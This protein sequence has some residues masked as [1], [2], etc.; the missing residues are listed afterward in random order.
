[1]KEKILAREKACFDFLNAMPKDRR[2][3]MIGGYAV[4]AFEF[5]RLSVDLDITI[6]QSELKFFEKL[7]KEN[8]F[9]LSTEK[10][11]IDKVYSGKF[12]KFVKKVELPVSVDLLI[13]SVKSRQTGVSYSFD[14]LYENSEAREVAGWHPESRVNVRA[15]D[16][17]MLIALKINSMRLTDKRDVI[18]LCYE[19]PD[20]DKIV[21]HLSRCPKD[22]IERHVDELV[23]LMEDPKYVDSIK[24]TF[25]ISEDVYKR[26]F[27]NCKIM[28]KEIQKKLFN[29]KQE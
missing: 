4:S 19:K 14:Y 8:G 24:G 29:A 26:A 12:K 17:E 16:R 6:P 27:K 9:E 22:I 25:S 13:N 2:Y 1:M 20:A 5:P 21:R 15:T 23:S 10:S 18:V 11:D 3:V 28:L 7:V